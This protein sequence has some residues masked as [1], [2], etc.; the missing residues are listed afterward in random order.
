MSR[1]YRKNLRVGI[2]T[3]S[4][5]EYYRERRRLQRRKLNQELHTLSSHYTVEAMEEDVVNNPKI[6]K[7]NEWLEPTDGRYLITRH[8]KDL[9]A[10]YIKDVRYLMKTKTA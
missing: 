8:N 10:S 6:P 7:V 1:T 4:N 2:C 5:T 3:G 9:H